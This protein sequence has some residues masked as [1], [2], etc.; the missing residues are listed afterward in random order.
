M[1]RRWKIAA[2][3]VLAVGLSVLL[4]ALSFRGFTLL[5]AYG[6][7]R[8]WWDAPPSFSAWDPKERIDAAEAEARKYGDKP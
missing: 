5:K 7:A 3:V 2:T 6:H 8:H 1:K 4:F